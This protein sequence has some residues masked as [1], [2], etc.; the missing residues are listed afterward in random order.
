MRSFSPPASGSPSNAEWVAAPT[1]PTLPNRH[2]EVG[3]RR[4]EL[5]QFRP[6]AGEEDRLNT[7]RLLEALIGLPQSSA[8]ELRLERRLGFGTPVVGAVQLFRGTTVHLLPARGSTSDRIEPR[9]RGLR[10]RRPCPT[11]RLRAGLELAEGRLGPERAGAGGR[12]VDGR[13]NGLSCIPGPRTSAAGATPSTTPSQGRSSGFTRPNSSI[14][15]TLGFVSRTRNS[16]PSDGSGSSIAPASSDPSVTSRPWS[17]RSRTVRGRPRSPSPWHSS[18]TPPM[19][20]GRSQVPIA[21]KRG[22]W[23]A[24]PA[25]AGVGSLGKTGLSLRDKRHVDQT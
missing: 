7:D 4:Q 11:H 18:Q 19:N 22:E 2:L 3:D 5:Q 8:S 20:P 13:R 10:D 24:K 23:V 15:G 9:L 1:T 12:G 16:P 6:V 25:P 21:V 17:S 14:R